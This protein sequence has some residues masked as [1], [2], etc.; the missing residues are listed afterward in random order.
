MKKV[1]L[2]AFFVAAFISTSNAARVYISNEDWRLQAGEQVFNYDTEIN[3]TC[4]IH[5]EAETYYQGVTVEIQVEYSG[6]N[7]HGGARPT[8]Y[9]WD[10]YE[11][12]TDGSRTQFIET[13]DWAKV[14]T[15]NPNGVSNS[16][17]LGYYYYW[18]RSIN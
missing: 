15:R 13:L 2:L 16:Y 3:K 9:A 17:G 14:I 7:Q 18:I 5:L 6:G 1:I 10:P 4:H 8:L 11:Y 12:T